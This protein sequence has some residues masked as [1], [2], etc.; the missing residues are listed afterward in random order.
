MRPRL[1]DFCLRHINF[2]NTTDEWATKP[3]SS[4]TQKKGV[5][6]DG[7]RRFHSLAAHVCRLIWSHHHHHHHP[8]PVEKECGQAGARQAP[9]RVAP[10]VC[11]NY[12]NW[13]HILL[14]TSSPPAI[15][16]IIIRFT[17]R[18]EFLAC[19]TATIDSCP[20]FTYL[21]VHWNITGL[22]HSHFKKSLF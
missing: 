20:L 21:N 6:N 22:Q 7:R 3:C 14:F 16:L 2:E 12:V 8:V 17:T 1:M 9:L 15:R 11:I 4:V 19:T 18:F 13:F 10:G 5:G